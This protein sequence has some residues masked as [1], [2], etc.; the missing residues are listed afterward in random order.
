MRCTRTPEPWPRRHTAAGADGAAQPWK[1]LTLETTLDYAVAGTAIAGGKDSDAV[2]QLEE[3][4]GAISAFSG[5]IR[6][7][8]GLES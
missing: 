7:C 2:P 8:A 3:G 5:A 1:T 6:K 4:N